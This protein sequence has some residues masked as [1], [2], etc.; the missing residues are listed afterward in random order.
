M[1]DINEI[2]EEIKKLEHSDNTTYSLCQKLASL[3]IVREH[4]PKEEQKTMPV[5]EIPSPLLK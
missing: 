4:L 5:M 2:N 3:Y 1:V